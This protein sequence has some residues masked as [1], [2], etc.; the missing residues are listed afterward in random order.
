MEFRCMLS[1]NVPFLFPGLFP[2]GRAYVAMFPFYSFWYY[3]RGMAGVVP[4]T[5]IPGCF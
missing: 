3:F 1:S 5:A 2:D 4:G